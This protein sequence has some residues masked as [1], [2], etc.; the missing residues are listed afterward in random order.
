MGETQLNPLVTPPLTWI[1]LFPASWRYAT[2]QSVAPPPPQNSN[3]GIYS[4]FDPSMAIIILILVSSFVFITLFSIYVRHCSE[5]M[6]SVPPPADDGSVKRGLDPAVIRTFPTFIYS[7]VKDLKLGKGALECAVCLSEFEDDETLRLIP[8]CD[9]VFHPDCIDLWLGSHVTCPNQNQNQN[10]NNSVSEIV[11]DVNDEL[12]R[13]NEVQLGETVRRNDAVSLKF[14]RSHSTGHSLVL[15]GVNVERYTLRLPVEIRKQLI[16]GKIKRTQ[17]FSVVLGREGTSRKGSYR[18]GGDGS[19]RGKRNM[20]RWVLSRTT[21]FVSKTRV[22][23]GRLVREKD[24]RPAIEY[25][26]G[27]GHEIEGDEPG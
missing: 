27:R 16:N 10:E 23:F 22:Y 12:S 5:T 20:D 4:N 7:A 9:H 24:A 21:P 18:S 8:K 25:C 2:A 1:L 26:D 15:A 17:S 3:L 13:S 6:I 11:I 14:P 19:N